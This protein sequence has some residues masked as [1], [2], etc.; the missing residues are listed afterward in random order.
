MSPD[1]HDLLVRTNARVAEALWWLLAFAG[2][3]LAVALV[4]A[5]PGLLERGTL[6]VDAL[7]V[8]GRRATGIAMLTV[9]PVLAMSLVVEAFAG[10]WLMPAYV[11]VGMLIGFGVIRVFY[12][13]GLAGSEQEVYGE[14]LAL[15]ALGGVV[16]GALRCRLIPLLR[17]AASGERWQLAPAF[18][19]AGGSIIR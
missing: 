4:L 19:A 13:P 6:D 11:L 18:A 3:A 2:A 17:E 15:G 14:F 16:L 9:L 1:H 7:R 8:I 5:G 12:F 10:R